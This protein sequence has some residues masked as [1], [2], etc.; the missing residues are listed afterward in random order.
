MLEYYV[1]I[2]CWCVRVSICLPRNLLY[3]GYKSQTVVLLLFCL[4]FVFTVLDETTAK[5]MSPE[6]VAMAILNTVMYG[7]RD[8][9]IGSLSSRIAIWLS[10]F[11]PSVLDWV[12][13]RRAGK[14]IQPKQ[15]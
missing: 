9:I 6:S 12:L 11:C 8:L 5:G 2:V 3:N 14:A 10:F 7:D 1:Y 4:S 13:R 15:Q